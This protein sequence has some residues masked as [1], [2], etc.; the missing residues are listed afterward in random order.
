MPW[1]LNTFEVPQK[2]CCFGSHSGKIFVHTQD[3]TV[4]QNIAHVLTP[5]GNSESQSFQPFSKFQE[6]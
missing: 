2:K 4:A 6:V 5:K 1:L 3:I